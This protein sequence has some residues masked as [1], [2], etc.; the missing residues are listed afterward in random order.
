VFKYCGYP[1][2]ETVNQNASGNLGNA[3]G[4]KEMLSR[5]MKYSARLNIIFIPFIINCSFQFRKTALLGIRCRSKA[6]SL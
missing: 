6:F 2:L 4:M 5:N 3:K 1:E